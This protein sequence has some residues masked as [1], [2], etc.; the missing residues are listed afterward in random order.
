MDSPDQSDDQISTNLKFGKF[1]VVVG[2]P[3]YN[4]E[5]TIAKI[6]LQLRGKADR[7]LVCDDGSEDMTLDIARAL[8]CKVIRHAHNLGKGAAL[9]SLFIA[10]R[11]E[12][13]D[14]FV[15]IDGDGQHNPVDVSRLVTL[16]ADDVCD[17]AIGSRFEDENSQVEMPGYRKFGSSIL[18]SVVRKTSSVSAKDTQS[19]FRA[20]SREAMTRITPGE[21]GIAADSEIL[22]LASLEGLRVKEIST[23]IFYDGLDT[24]A[25]NP[26]S[27][28]MEVIGGSLKF[29]SLR[30]PLIFYGIPSIAFLIVSIVLGVWML[31]YYD[32]VGRLPFGPTVGAAASFTIAMVLGAVAVI[33][34]SLSTVIRQKT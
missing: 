32:S 21:E 18:N 1:K 17:I 19:G 22:Q 11:E 2:I 16:V 7:I 31:L 28:S 29:I 6:I 25:R 27:H 26:F 30:H 13:P 33:L 34:F 4:E 15:T 3:C 23:K 12:E 20:Y 14:V 5:K 9:R 24:S 8:G 10:A